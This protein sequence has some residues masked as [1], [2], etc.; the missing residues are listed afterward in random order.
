MKEPN[1]NTEEN[2][3]V[4]AKKDIAERKLLPLSSDIVFKRVFSREENNGILKDLLESIL[5]IKIDK[6]EVKNPELPIN[7]YDDKA[8][9]LDIKAEL[10]GNITCDIEMQVENQY[11]IDKRTLKYGS[12]LISGQ[13]K[14][15]DRYENL[16]KVIT[17][18]ILKFN[19][20]KR[21]SY[22]S[23]AHMWFDK[24]KQE[25]Y[26]DTKCEKE[27]EKATEDFEMHFIELPKF[28][29]KNPEVASRLDQWLWLIDGDGG[30]IKMAEAKNEK[31]G[32][33]LDSIKEMSM[34][35][36][37]WEL[38]ESRQR[39]IAD[40]ENTKAHLLREG[41]AQGKKE[42]IDEGRK[43]EAKEIARKLLKLNMPIEQIT[44]ITE[45]TKEEI[46]KLK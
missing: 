30:K 27:D 33:A 20:Y 17:I 14:S 35:K 40:Q 29:K 10:N 44:E 18:S 46:E 28:K 9:I 3:E 42:G 13:L 45:L 19:Y 26:V 2:I 31:I 16:H 39:W 41:K 5:N 23:V 36:K 21:N 37:E 8:G 7:L 12:S 4:K 32:E 38:Y 22:H 43:E 6:V 11:N 15:G 25:E 34:D 1:E 24:T